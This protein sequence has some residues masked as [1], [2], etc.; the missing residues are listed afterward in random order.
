MKLANDKSETLIE[1]FV[2]SWSADRGSIAKAP[3]SPKPPLPKA[4][5]L[6][7]LKQAT[8][9]VTRRWAETPYYDSV[10]KRA[11]SQWDHLISPFLADHPIDYSAVLELADGHG[12]KTKI[13]LEKARHVTGVDV[14]QE[15]IDFC[16]ERFDGVPN[17]TLIRND[18]L[19][20]NAVDDN[21]ISFAFCFDSMVHFDSDVV[22]AYL[23]EFYRVLRPGGMAFCHH[24][25]LT[26][27]PDGNIRR[28]PHSRNFMSEALFRH[29]AGKKGLTV[30]KS[31]VI[32]W[33]TG[34]R[35]VAGL[36]CLSLIRKAVS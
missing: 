28:S 3:A 19:A 29:L 16:A 9:V 15:N 14:L 31:Q 26:R 30:V 12:R 17:I 4:D 13:L 20:L 36:D 21:S 35:F 5:E 33:G 8:A 2:D 11:R 24:S 22:R 1:Q 34:E 27:N 32:D 25:N 23:G 6:E 7:Q 18:G 10:E